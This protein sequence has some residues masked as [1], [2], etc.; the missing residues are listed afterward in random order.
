MRK[1]RGKRILA[2]L[3]TCMISTSASAADLVPVS[4]SDVKTQGYE[5]GPQVLNMELTARY[6]DSAMNADG[7]SMEIVTYDTVRQIA[8]V[9]S[10]LRG[11]VVSV[12]LKQLENGSTVQ[13]LT[14]TAQYD[15]SA[16]VSDDTFTYGDITSV[17]ISPDGSQL[18]VAVQHADYTQPGRIAV[19]D[20]NEAGALEQRAMTLVEAGVQPDMVTFTPDGRHILS[21]N[22]GEPR[23]GYTAQGAVDPAGSVTLVDAGTLTAVTLGFD[24]FDHAELA[25]QGVV[26][27]KGASPAVDL[28]PEYIAASNDTAYVALQE[29]NAIAVLD[30]NAR[31][32]TGIYS[33]GFEDYSTVKLD[34]DKGDETYAPANYEN[35]LGIRMP[36][37]ISLYS[38]D[39]LDYLLTANEGDGR[40]WPVETEAD[41]NEI[42]DK[43]SPSGKLEMDKKVTWFDAAQYDGL[44]EGVDYLFG[45]RTLT[46]FRVTESGLEEVFTSGSDFEEK[47]F[48]YLPEVFNCSN[49][50]VEPEDRSGKKGPEPETV[51]VG[52]VNGRTYAFVALERIGGVMAYDITDPTQAQ[53]VNYI[54]SREFDSD[55]QGDVAPEGL[56]FIPAG[57]GR[58]AMLLAACEVSGTV[59]VYEL[60]EAGLTEPTVQTSPK[61]YVVAPGDCLWNIA[62]RVYGSGTQWKKIYE[63]NSDTIKVPDLIYVGT[64]LVL[65]Q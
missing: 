28:E 41:S 56:T 60:R 55:V 17:C 38:V 21:A 36:D 14:N 7:G 61:T 24:A 43:V 3:L 12:P 57:G 44:Q 45:G 6:N 4:A 27:K 63:A 23:M 37:G 19:F 25:A 9:V 22:E 50:N 52:T 33:L 40:A 48:E 31:N 49:D 10:G 54:N 46:M 1:H 13:S 47:T 32:F 59:A 30:L 15:L 35:L 65:P 11:T 16:W 8:Y 5:N 18:A 39:G 64:T 42:K 62:A 20:L 53:Y 51:T 26:L 58:Q 2:I 29:A 34:L